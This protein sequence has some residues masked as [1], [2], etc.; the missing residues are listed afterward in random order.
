[1]E[2]LLKELADLNVL[3]FWIHFENQPEDSIAKQCLKISKEFADKNQISL[4]QKVNNLCA[5]SNLN[6]SNL[7]KNNH[8]SFLSQ[9]R[10]SLNKRI[11]QHQLNLIKCNKKLKFYSQFRTDCHKAD[12]LNPINNPLHE[13]TLNKFRLGNHQLLIETGR[14]TIPKTP[15]NLRICPFCHLNEVE[16]ETHLYFLVNFTIVYAP[17]FFADVNERYPI[18]NDLDNNLKIIFLVNNIDPFICR[19]TA[20]YAHLCMDLRQS[21][22]I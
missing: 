22:V 5:T 21:L 6:T 15:E 14:H 3:K 20:A 9:I 12:C 2:R 19:R 10:S 18:F 13:K 16:N 1:M 4:V 7:T 8:S 17:S 11:I